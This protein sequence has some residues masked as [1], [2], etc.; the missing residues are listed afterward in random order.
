RDLSP[1][2]RDP[3]RHSACHTLRVTASLAFL[4]SGALLRSLGSPVETLAIVTCRAPP[5]TL[6]LKCCSKRSLSV[7]TAPYSSAC[8]LGPCRSSSCRTAPELRPWPIARPV[9]RQWPSCRYAPGSNRVRAKCRPMA[10]SER[11]T[12]HDSPLVSWSG[13]R[14]FALG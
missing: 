5:A 7:M 8:A 4:S 13:S 9:Q 3:S 6:F 14:G 12:L 11:F 1:L 2:L 10:R